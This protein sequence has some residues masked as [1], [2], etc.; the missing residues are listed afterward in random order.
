MNSYYYLH[1][2]NNMK[3]LIKTGVDIAH[4]KEVAKEVTKLYKD[5][6]LVSKSRYFFLYLT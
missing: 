4:T 2:Q 6:G 3:F 5:L 1:K